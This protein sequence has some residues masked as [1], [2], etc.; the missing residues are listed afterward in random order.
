MKKLYSILSILLFASTAF[1]QLDTTGGRYCTENF[2]SAVTTTSNITYGSA[3]TWSGGTQTLVM[4]IYQPTGD[5]AA[6]R[7]LI[8]WAHGG[9]F[10][11]GART[12]QDVTTL[13]TRFAKM[14][15]VCASIDYRLGMFP[16]DS[17]NA[18]KAVIRAVQ[19]MKAAIRF[20]RKDV[21]TTNTYRIDPLYIMAGGSS[22]GAFMALHSAYLDRTTEAA[23]WIANNINSLGGLEGNSGNPGYSSKFNAVINLCGALGDS[24]WLEAGNI[25][26]VSMHGTSDNVVPYGHQLLYVSGFPIMVVDGSSTIKM[27]ADN[28]GVLNPFHTWY[29]APHVPYAGTSAT[30][31]AYM[32]STVD[33]VRAF[34]CPI[35]SA[36]SI[37]T[38]VKEIITRQG[39][40]IYPNPSSGQFTVRFDEVTGRTIAV[41]DLSGRLIEEVQFNGTEYSFSRPKLNAGVY[42]VKVTA[43]NKEEAVKK[44]IITD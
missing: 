11:G 40:S 27:R 23:T 7:G 5:V 9:S 12:D 38:N 36:P 13:C 6:A 10:I 29:G 4:D 18:S 19:D 1:A 2:F 44:I 25:P 22:A 33:F 26:L 17:T 24:T 41:T 21:A 39:F 15:W 16:I 8:V 3:T 37:F 34:L 35:A 31:M 43:A 28:V 14:G 30:Q 20:F 42:F 32:D